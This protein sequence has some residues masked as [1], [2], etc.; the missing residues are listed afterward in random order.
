[1]KTTADKRLFVVWL[2]LVAIT[3]IYLR[4]DNSA[5]DHGVRLASTSVTVAAICLALAKVWLIAREFM[6]HFK[7][8]NLLV[9][10]RGV[11]YGIALREAERR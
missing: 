9:S 7:F 1:M 5:D 2:I 6:E 8:Q 11:R 3:L 10:E 4:I